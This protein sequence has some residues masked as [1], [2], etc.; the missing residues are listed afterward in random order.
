MMTALAIAA[1]LLVLAMSL[2]W[3]VQRATGNS[4]WIDT[5]W[6]FAVGTASVIGLMVLPAA[7]GRRWLLGAL[8]L[9][10]SGRLGWHILRRTGQITDDPRYASLMAQWGEAAPRRLFLFLQTQA[11]AGLVLVAAVLLAATAPASPASPASILL[12]ALAGLALIGEAVADAQ[13]A[14]FKRNP[15]AS[16]ICDTGLWAFSRHPNYLCEWLFW[17]AIAGLAITPP[18]GWTSLLALAA[19][20]MM[21]ALLRYASGVPHLEAHLQRTRPE[22]FAEYAARVPVFFP[23]LVPA[24]RSTAR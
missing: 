6:S 14:A 9:V 10:W 22:A 12:A 23:R 16:R 1:I 18:A 21:Y 8:V 20:A 19:P 2:A 17:V 15:S 13:L 3:A 5:T 11:A 24:R 4:G 7:P